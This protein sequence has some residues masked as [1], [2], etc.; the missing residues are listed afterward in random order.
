VSLSSP[1]SLSSISLPPH[2]LS[3]FS[4]LSHRS[5][6]PCC[7]PRALPP[8]RAQSVARSACRVQASARAGPCARASRARAPCRGRATRQD[9]SRAPCRDRRAA[10]VYTINGASLLPF[11]P[12]VSPSSPLLSP[13]LFSGNVASDGHEGQQRPIEALSGSD[14]SS[15]LPLSIKSSRALSHSFLLELASSSSAPRSSL[16]PLPSFVAVRRRSSPEP[17]F[18]G[19]TPSVVRSRAL[20]FSI[21]RNPVEHSLS[22]VRTQG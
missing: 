5:L 21:R 2:S 12:S 20:L 13:S 22:H 10:T 6:T 7:T 3:L 11:L 17:Q 15:P 8:C 19:A 1:Y 14:L 18:A 4:L 9:A 16:V